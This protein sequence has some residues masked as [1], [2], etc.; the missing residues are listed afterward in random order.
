MR[1]AT[2]APP[3]SSLLPHRSLRNRESRPTDDTVWVLNYRDVVYGRI[4]MEN[5][6]WIIRYIDGS[7]ESLL[8]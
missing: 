3:R 8:W 7:W 1:A 2:V 5:G 6:V 4:A